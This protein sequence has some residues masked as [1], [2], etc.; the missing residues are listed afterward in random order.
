MSSHAILDQFFIPAIGQIGVECLALGRRIINSDNGS[1]AKFF[2]EQ[3]PLLSANSVEEIAVAMETIIN[4]P[5][6]T[7]GYGAAARKWFCKYHSKQSLTDKMRQTI[8]LL[9]IMR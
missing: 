5:L 6:D 2:G 7:V 1:L 9:D 8:K 3:P 4:D